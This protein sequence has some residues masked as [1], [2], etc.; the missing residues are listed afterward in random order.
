MAGGRTP[1]AFVGREDELG[2]L[3][4]ALADT[5]RRKGRLVLV[6]GEPGIG[7]S[8]L[9]EELVAGAGPRRAGA[10]RAAAGRRAARRRTGPGCRRCEPTCAS[11][12]RTPAGRARPRR[13]RRGTGGAGGARALPEPAE[14]P[15]L[16]P[17]GA[18]FRLFDSVATFLRNAARARPLAGRARRLHAADAPRCCCSS[19]WPASS[20][21]P[22]DDPRAPTA[23]RKPAPATRS[24]ATLAEIA[25]GGL[26]RRSC[27]AA[28]SRG[29]RPRYIEL[30]RAWSAPDSL[31][32]ALHRGHQRQPA[33]SHRAGAPPE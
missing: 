27:S 25:R 4:T 23:T 26:P 8:R 18:R 14:P 6:G 3:M 30:A 33:V 32:A 13:R 31:V 10:R 15:A 2:A 11:A 9:A 22:R 7:K 28:S 24:S 17:D 29:G 20:M 21:G 12:S 16:A 5:P 1:S 19:S